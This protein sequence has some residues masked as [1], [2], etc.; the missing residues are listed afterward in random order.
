MAAS[1]STAP[2]TKASAAPKT[3][4][5]RSARGSPPQDDIPPLEWVAA[6]VGLSL[7]ATAIGLT[8]WDAVFGVDTPPAIEVRLTAVTPT[9]YGYV[10]QIEAFN[11]GGAAA[12]QVVVEGA[13]AGTTPE[14]ASATFD[15]IPEQSRAAGGLIF[16]HD[17]REAPLKLRATG[18]IDAS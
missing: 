1:R 17:P 13:L 4:A 5:P 8:A 16:E 9:P 18:F 15:Y 7:A 11:H 14:T 12:A 2:R 10:A 3:A 6:A